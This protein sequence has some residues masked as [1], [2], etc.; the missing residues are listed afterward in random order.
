MT[1]ICF[2][3]S[4]TFG[5]DPRSPLG[6]R[7][8]ESAR[9]VDILAAKTGWDVRNNGMNARVIPPRETIVSKS[10]DI[11]I[12]LLGTNNLLQGDDVYTIAARMAHFL[13]L[14]SLDKR[15]VLLISP[16][17]L[18]RGEWVQNDDWIRASKELAFAYLCVSKQIGTMYADAG[19]WGIPLA[20]DGIHFTEEGHR[21]FAE[22]LLEL[23]IFIEFSSL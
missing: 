18:Q 20:F 21:I 1:V 8:E 13:Y 2:G 7:Y 6:G 16:P 11:L 19:E 3:D 10:A 17:P 14:L 15:K 12:V 4:N 22:K 9:W 5:Y 23:P